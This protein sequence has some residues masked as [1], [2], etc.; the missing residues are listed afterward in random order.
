VDEFVRRLW[1]LVQSIPQYRGK[2]TFIITLTT[3][4]Q[5]AFRLEK[6]RRKD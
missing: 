5:R 3:A 2:T 1:E 6:P 4:A